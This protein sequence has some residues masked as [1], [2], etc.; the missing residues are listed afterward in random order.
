M[1]TNKKQSIKIK[2]VTPKKTV[3]G[4]VVFS[5]AN[6]VI[7]VIDLSEVEL[8]APNKIKLINKRI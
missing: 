4:R 2:V 6:K 5:H 8:K 7:D 1:N 3:A